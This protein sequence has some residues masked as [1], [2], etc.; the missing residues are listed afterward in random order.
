MNR[1]LF[2]KIFHQKGNPSPK[3]ISRKNFTY[4]IIIWFI[5]SYLKKNSQKILDIGCGVGAV[6]IFLANQGH[7]VTGIDISEKAVE[8]CKKS[9]ILATVAENTKFRVVD[10]PN[11]SVRDKN[12]D[13]ALCGEVL[14]HLQNDKIALKKIFT[15]LKP[16][17]ILILSVPSLNAPLYKLRFVQRVDRQVGHLRRYSMEKLVELCKSV[18][19]KILDVRETEGILRNSL[20]IFYFGNQLLRFLNRFSILSDTLTLLDN[21][22]LKLFGGSQFF[23][24]AQKP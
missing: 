23:I 2:Y 9:A 13:L 5:E 4:R 18:G 12:F 20:F 6:D 3:I 10:F 14:E 22:A 11:E 15:I 8:I 24:I 17:G 1:Q 7:K 21:I 16:K 19:F